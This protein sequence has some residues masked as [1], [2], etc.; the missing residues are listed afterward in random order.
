MI[1]ALHALGQIIEARRRID[2]DRLQIGMPEQ[3][4]QAA[5]ITGVGR[6][7]AGRKG[8]TQRMWANGVNPGLTA[9]DREQPQDGAAVEQR[10]AFSLARVRPSV[11]WVLGR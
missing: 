7:V 6:Q 3:R 4:G 9:V 2:H 5:Q 10:P 8:V 11:P 1:H